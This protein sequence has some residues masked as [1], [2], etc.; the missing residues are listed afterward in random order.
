MKIVFAT[1]IFPPDSG[2]PATYVE[3][4]S[5]TLPGG[6]HVVVTYSDDESLRA[7]IAKSTRPHRLRRIAGGRLHDSQNAMP[8]VIRISRRLPL[9]FRYLKYAWQIFKAA[10]K[11]DV[12]YAQGPVSE[13]FPA[14]LGAMLAGRPVVMKVVGDYA[15][16]QARQNGESRLLDAYLSS[17]PKGLRDRIERWTARR[18]Q[19]VIVPSQY[20][21][22]VV[23]KWGVSDEQIHVVKNAA[24]T[25]ANQKNREDFRSENA[26]SEK[27]VFF[28]AVR[29]VPWKGVAEL[30]EWWSDLPK[31][32][33]LVVAGDG[34]ELEAWKGLAR[35]MSLEDRIRFVGRIPREEMG[36]W[37]AAADAFIL[38]SGYEGYPHVIPEAA[39]F[40]L[41]CFV[42]DMGGNPETA[43]DFPGLVRIMP[44]QNKEVWIAELSSFSAWETREAYP[45][46][47][48]FNEVCRETLPIL[49]DEN[50]EVHVVMVSYEKELLRPNSSP[51]TR[52]MSM[53]KDGYSIS[54]LVISAL[55]SNEDVSQNVPGMNVFAWRGGAFR[56]VYQAIR[57]GVREVRRHR[58]HAVVTAQDPFVAGLLGYCIS[59]IANVPLEIQEHGDFYSGFWVKES[60]KNRMLSPLGR[61][62]LRR[63]ERVR[64]VSER[65]K[66]NL[67]RIGVSEDRIEVIPVAHELAFHPC[68]TE[69]DG[70]PR[71]VVPCRFVPQKGIDTLL[72][73]AKILKER[74]LDFQVDLVGKGPEEKRVRSEVRN[75]DLEDRV[76]IL[77]WMDRDELFDR[78]DLF[79]LSSRYEGWGRTI[80]EAMA[81]GV[82][83][84]TTDVGC[85]GSFFRP[86]IDGRVVQPNDA[87]GLATAIY[88]Q[89]TDPERRIALC[90]NARERAESLPEQEAL[91]T[92]QRDGWA[93]LLPW[94]TGTRWELWLLSLLAFAVVMRLASTF[95]FH[96]SLINREWGFFALVDHWFKGYGYSYALEPGCLSAWRSPGYLFFLTGLYSLFSPQN[97]LAHALAQNLVVVGII[98]LVYAVGRRL[99][100]RRAAMIAAFVMTV[101]PYT[102]YHYT[103]Y[104]HT[105]LSSFFLLLLMWF[106]LRLRED[107]GM[108]FAV[109]SGISIAALAYVQGT[110][111]PATPFIVLWL[112]WCWWPDWKQVF[113]AAA[114]MAVVSA[115]L[116]A[117]WTYRNWTAFHTLVPLTTDLGHALI[118]ANSENIYW[119]T[120]EGYPQEVQTGQWV[121]SS[122]NPDYKSYVPIDEVLHDP[123]LQPS[124]L[125]DEWH[126]KEPVSVAKTCQELGPLNEAEFNQ[127]WM[128]KTSEARKQ[129]G[130]AA[131]LK[132][133]LQKIKTFWQPSLFPSVKRGAP[134]SFADSPIKVWLARTAVTVSAAF[135]ILLGAVGLLWR[136]KKKDKNA[137]LALVVLIVYTV[138]HSF[139]AG[140]TKYRIPLDNIMAIYAGCAIVLFWDILRKRKL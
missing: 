46:S 111:L 66:K 68:K 64:A 27:T 103:Q 43:E 24:A 7:G 65:I 131:V 89:L 79:V 121:T 139:F 4:M 13:G 106:V 135:V 54:A 10:R 85:V 6:G 35:N 107:R 49:H 123:R 84:V 90:K 29:A 32:H 5:R 78:A 59:R 20:L 21:K 36:N 82:P 26:I 116:I 52:V 125:F 69:V 33:I 98:W 118:K 101:Y 96:E 114:V 25:P 138:M 97:T 81:H 30:I 126:P 122:T 74:G 92:K 100:G 140:Y 113:K 137:V 11:A 12:V 44:Y 99:A 76:R 105:F 3:M 17:R 133:H 87:E 132:L 67:I 58:G 93:T 34:P 108:R 75:M 57:K 39:S 77:P 88:E 56:R 50:R 60:W 110:I 9:P 41:P 40:G 130:P 18:A 48:D 22:T 83:I 134:W 47:R 63:A 112:L 115:G 127:Y 19:N 1:G 28:T 45:H 61:A 119:L 109:G 102:F 16:E 128:E 104:Y 15:W 2:G 62:L 23:Q 38:H 120:E 14:T 136:V 80:V 8:D 94:N 71:I 53:A 42:S 72:R 31:S 124:I 86:Q 73:A 95:L 117:P 51:W 55:A 70:D 129:M 91:H 37:F